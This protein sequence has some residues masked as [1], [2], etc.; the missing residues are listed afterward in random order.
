MISLKEVQETFYYSVDSPSK[1]RWNVDK[2]SGMYRTTHIVKKGSPAGG[3]SVHGYWEVKHN[4]RCYKCHRLV[5]M[6]ENCC[7]LADDVQIGH[8][9]G[10]RGDNLTENLLKS[11]AKLNARNKS[12]RKASKT[13]I[14]GVTV[15]S[16]GQGNFYARATWQEPD[17][18]DNWKTF[19]FLM[20]GE[21]V[22]MELAKQCRD[23]NMIRLQNMGC[24]YS[25][26]HLQASQM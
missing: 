6:L 10:V 25:E 2:W 19:S 13:G 16:N 26:R 23:E 22:A 15:S 11:C 8:S 24:N 14:N 18:S 9:N 3:L 5:Y 7:E 20:Y 21:D 1:I 4:G 12:V 17:G